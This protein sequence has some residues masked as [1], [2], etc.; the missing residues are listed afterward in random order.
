MLA[1]NVQILI[2][3]QAVAVVN[4]V[5]NVGVVP[6][7]KRGSYVVPLEELQAEERKGG[8]GGEEPPADAKKAPKKAG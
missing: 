6:K 1:S 3:G 7:R 4:D 2:C 5:Y 8:G